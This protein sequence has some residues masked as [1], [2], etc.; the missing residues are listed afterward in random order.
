MAVTLRQ[1]GL[2]VRDARP[3]D[4]EPLLALAAASPMRGRMRLCIDRSPDFFALNRLEGE[5]WRV[6]VAETATAGI[7]G[8]V[9]VAQRTAYVRGEPR[10]T[11]YV[12]DLKVHPSFR[13]QAGP[14]ELGAADALTRYCVDACRELGPDVPALLTIL[15]GNR[16]ME[17]RIMGPRGLP[18]LRRFATVRAH[19]VPL[20]WKRRAPRNERRQ[21]EAGR[22]QRAG[23]RDVEE[24]A[25]LWARVAPGRQFAPVFDAATFAAWI[26][27]APGLSISDYLLARSPRGRL[28]G[29]LGLWD[30]ECFKRT[31][32]LSYARGAALFK[33]VFN[34]VAPL[35][36]AP[37]LPPPGAPLRYRTAVHVCVA[38][39]DR[40]VLRQLLVAGYNSLRGQDY[41][42][43]TVGL[44]VRDPLNAALTGLWAQ[45]TDIHAYITTAGGAYDGPPLDD[46][47][48]HYEIA[49]V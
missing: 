34:A 30:Q 16:A 6:G 43:F 42:F 2:Y 26:E 45:P 28:L 23:D 21:R 48:L 19:S 29:F 41:A 24:M 20:L 10:S 5:Q 36:G 14:G 49:L 15:G 11:A 18:T 31:R 22:V 46:R 47:A 17:R 33:T 32:V 13:G 25:A 40:P 35:A 44:D 27:S 4:N 39:W 37:R 1:P 12:S 38:N 3:D 9:A 8:C 7:V